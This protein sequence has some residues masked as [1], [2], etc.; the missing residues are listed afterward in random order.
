M[1]YGDMPL[2][3]KGE[4]EIIIKNLELLSWVSDGVSHPQLSL[5][6]DIEPHLNVLYKVESKTG[7]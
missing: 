1:S 7:K 5:A 4:E 3:A 6:G 2:G